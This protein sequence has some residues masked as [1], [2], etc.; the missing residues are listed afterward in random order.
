MS[1][2]GQNEV[3]TFFH[4]PAR[5]V[6]TLSVGKRFLASRQ[7]ACPMPFPRNSG[8]TIKKPIWH[9]SILSLQTTQPTNRPSKR[10]VLMFYMFQ[11]NICLLA[12]CEFILWTHCW[13]VEGSIS[14]RGN[15]FY[16][17]YLIFSI[18]VKF[19]VHSTLRRLFIKCSFKLVSQKVKYRLI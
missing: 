19:D 9:R 12:S 4:L 1:V 2:G 15:N 8:T 10:F 3:N 14:I 5:K 6:R 7:M 11:W 17:Y 16:S 18:V 13:R